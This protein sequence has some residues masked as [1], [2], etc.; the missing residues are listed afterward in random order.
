[1]KIQFVSDL[2]LECL[3]DRTNFRQVLPL[4]KIKGDVL[5]LAGDICRAP[6]DLDYLQE[7]GIPILYILGNH[8]YYYHR[9]PG[10]LQVLQGYFNT[11]NIHV[12]NNEVKLIGDIKFICS[13]M[14]TDLNETF[15]S[16]LVK[17]VVNDFHVVGGLTVGKWLEEYWKSR[18]Y[19]KFCLAEKIPG[20]R[21]SVVVTHF[22]PSFKS[23]IRHKGSAISGAFCAHMDD[24]IERYQPP[25][26]IHGHTHD[27][28]DYKIGETRIIS[29]P[30]GYESERGILCNYN[31]DLIIEI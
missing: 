30:R 25:L 13:T 10:Q 4:E 2:H 6:S 8:E 28:V 14:W 26:W 18:G 7:A 20:E 29:N 22:A 24:I 31:P 21:T 23:E 5:I 3:R 11:G 27:A 17:E 12:L 19:I 16:R 1:M 9:F 15:C